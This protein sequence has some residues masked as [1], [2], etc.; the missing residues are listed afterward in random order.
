MKSKK[1]S[2]LNEMILDVELKKNLELYLEK[3]GIQVAKLI[4]RAVE[5]YITERQTISLDPVAME[6]EVETNSLEALQSDRFS[7]E[8]KEQ[9]EDSNPKKNHFMYLYH[10]SKEDINEVKTRVINAVGESFS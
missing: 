4:H 3:N 7:K 1:Q 10:P 6:E 8:I 2:A 9:I 5:K